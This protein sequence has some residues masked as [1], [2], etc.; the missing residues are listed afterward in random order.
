MKLS[1]LKSLLFAGAGLLLPMASANAIT[2][3][4]LMRSG[5]LNSAIDGETDSGSGSLNAI[6]VHN[7]F[8]GTWTNEGTITSGT[9]G[10]ANDLLKINV[11]SGTLNGLSVSVTWT[12]DPSFWTH[13]G[14]AVIGW[15]V[16]SFLGDPD[17]F[18]FEIKPGETSGTWSYL[19][20]DL[21]GSIS[22]IQLYGSGPKGVGVPDNGSTVGLMGFAM[23]GMAAVRRFKKRK[24]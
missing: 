12:I 21:T 7:A 2:I 3:G 9:P 20:L 16:G 11:T 10:L 14:N 18:M 4:G 8:G 5:T 19:H 17:F 23:G 6:I 24:A 15:S 1:P 13:Y 22:D